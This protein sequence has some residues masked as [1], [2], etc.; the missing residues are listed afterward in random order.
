MHAER[1]TVA[2][3]RSALSRARMCVVDR[4]VVRPRPIAIAA[5]LAVITLVDILPRDELSLLQFGALDEAA[6][7][8]TVLLVLWS[9]R[10]PMPR[11]LVLAVLLGAVAIDIDHVI[12]I[13][14]S[15]PMQNGAP[16]PYTHSLLTPAVLVIVS[17][18][19]PTAIRVG[20]VG[21]ALGTLGHF[22][23]DIAT[24]DGML[25]FW[26]LSSTTVLL[27]YQLYA[28][29]V[30]LLAV[31]SIQRLRAGSVGRAVSSGARRDRGTGSAGRSSD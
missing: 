7:L 28:V 17:L 8:A 13:S 27:P 20:L 31:G 22:L 21:I 18:L 6:H 16:R 26:P 14:T 4:W 12:S 29:T 5:A 25:L 11:R 23:R 24:S 3:W 9:V 15:F 2:I 19:M 30:V 10:L 1:S